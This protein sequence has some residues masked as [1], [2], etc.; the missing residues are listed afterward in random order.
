MANEISPSDS[1]A[2]DAKMAGPMKIPSRAGKEGEEEATFMFRGSIQHQGVK[3][4]GEGL[5]LECQFCTELG[6]DSGCIQARP[7]RIL[8]EPVST[9]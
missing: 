4:K 2:G 5:S 6:H 8:R 3:E 9:S 1:T 7:L